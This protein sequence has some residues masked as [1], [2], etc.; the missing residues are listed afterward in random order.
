MNNPK[1]IIVHHEAPPVVVGGK[2]FNI[3]DNYHKAI[4]FPK[5]RLGWYV[6]YTFFIE[7]DG[8]IIRARQDDET[9]AHTV[10]YND[11]SIGICLAGNFD[12]ELP[13]KQQEISLGKLLAENAG[14]FKIPLE[15]IVPHR[16]FAIKSCYGR[17]LPD[18]WA[19]RVYLGEQISFLKRLL[20]KLFGIQI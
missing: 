14:K 3:V 16:K 10:G 20:F 5:S 1:Y 7:K 9:G 2:R 12:I 8:E 18:N 11:K 19:Q 6:G 17:K 15:N 4:N 13:T